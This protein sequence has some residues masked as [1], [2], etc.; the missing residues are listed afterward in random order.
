MGL[1]TSCLA[2]CCMRRSISAPVVR[3]KA[4]SANKPLDSAAHAPTAIPTSKAFGP[5]PRSRRWN[6]PRI[7]RRKPSVTEAEAA[8]V[9]TAERRDLNGDPAG[10]AGTGSRPRL[11]CAVLRPWHRA[12]RVEERRDIADRRS[13]GWRRSRPS[14]SGGR[15]RTGARAAQ[16]RSTALQDRPL[17]R[18]LHLVSVERPVRPCCRCSTTTT[19]RSS[20]ARHVS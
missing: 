16:S 4:H 15:K 2:G 12:G 1:E 7:C 10:D 6:A 3:A 19:I 9:R 8:A 11:Q 5:T 13:G 17:R 14:H 20:R 18:A